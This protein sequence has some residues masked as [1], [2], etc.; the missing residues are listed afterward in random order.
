MF[1][2]QSSRDLQKSVEISLCLLQVFS[3]SP[4][5]ESCVVCPQ[6]KKPTLKKS[7]NLNIYP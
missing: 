2:P 5:T 7:V 4:K 1:A 6:L 3:K